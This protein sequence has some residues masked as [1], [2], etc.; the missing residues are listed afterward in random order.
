MDGANYTATTERPVYL[1]SNLARNLWV[2][3]SPVL[4]TIGTVGNLLS[5]VVMLRQ[6]LRKCTTSLYLFVLAVMDTLVLYTGLLKDWIRQLFGVAIEDVSIAACRIYFFALYLT[7]QIEAWILV[8]V[9]VERM[10]AVFWPHKAKQIFTRTFAARQMAI[11]G[12]ILALINSH[13]FWTFTFVSE[14]NCGPHPRYEHFIKYVFSWIDTCLTSLVPYLIMLVTSSAIVAKLTRANQVRK[15]KLNVKRDKKL[16]SMTAILFSITG[17]F[18]LTTAPVTVFLSVIKYSK[19]NVAQYILH[20]DCLSLLFY[21]NYS[22]NFLLYCV[23]G[24]RFRREFVRMCWIKANGSRNNSQN[25]Y[26][27]RR[28]E[29]EVNTHECIDFQV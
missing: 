21:V 6:N 3:G 22:V 11:I 25:N 2:Y 29:A 7:I 19:R 16:T 8:C 13:F 23:S 27:R 14:P 24:P 15:V 17:I 1:E 28:L 9:G 12:V 26:A 20:L 4:I 18:L 5:A 10:V